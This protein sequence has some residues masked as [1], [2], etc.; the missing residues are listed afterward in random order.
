MRTR[1]SVNK[2]RLSSN[3]SLWM[4]GPYFSWRNTSQINLSWEIWKLEYL[5]IDS[6]QLLDAGCY[7]D[8]LSSVSSV[9]LLSP[10]RPMDCSMPGLPVHHQL[11]ELIHPHVH[12]VGDATKPSHPLS[13]PSPPA[14]N[15][16]QHQGLFK[17]VS[18]SYH[19]AK[20]LE[21]Q[22]QQQSSQWVFRT[23]LL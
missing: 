17:W 8:L 5:Y 14:F 13:P 23:D 15:L 11:P 16:S 22:L 19:V 10:V 18:S 6:Y 21:F 4:K 3:L 2:E 9:Q 20:W 1:K 12:W 7:W